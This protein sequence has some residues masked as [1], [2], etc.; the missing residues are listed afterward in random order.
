[1]A[2]DRKI[3][4]PV[5][6]DSYVIYNLEEMQAL[7]EYFGEGYLNRIITG[8]DSSSLP[9]MR[10]CLEVMLKEANITPDEVLKRYSFTEV[11]GWL[12]DAISMAIHGKRVT[13]R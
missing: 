13:V 5:S 12:L 2:V 10:K 7:Y 8:I 4:V 3:P 1:M 6:A 11:S 9:V